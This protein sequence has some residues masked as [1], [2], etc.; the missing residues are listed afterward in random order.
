MCG[1][2]GFIDFNSV[3]QRVNLE[4]M[5]DALL[6]RGPDA[7]GYSFH[8]NKNYT[9][10][11]GHRRLSILDLSELGK[12]P[13][14][15]EN[16]EIIYNGEVYNFREV[17]DELEDFGYQFKS[18]SDT[19]VILKSFHK[20]GVNSVNKFNGMFV[21]VIYDKERDQ[22]TIIRDRGGV[23]PCYYYY[24]DGLFLFS[25]ELKSFHQH[26]NFEKEIDIQVL[27]KY[28]QH[29]YIPE[30]YSI[31]KN[32]QKLKSGCYLE[33]NL[34]NKEFI[35]REYW[36]V[37][38]FYNKPKLAIGREEAVYQTEELMKLSFKYRMVSDVPVGI[39]LSGG[40]DSSVVTGLLQKDSTDKLKTFTI[41]FEEKGFDEAPY[42][43]QVANHLGT[44]HVEYYYTQ[45]DA[46]DIFPKLSE[47]FD[48]PFGDSSVIPTVLVSQLA[49]KDV[50]V[51]LSAD[52]GDELF[53]GYSKY[54]LNLKYWNKLKKSPSTLRKVMTIG[55]GW[56]DPNNIPLFNKKYNFETKYLKLQSLLSSKSITE[57]LNKRSQHFTDNQIS[58]L[59]NIKYSGIKT[60]FDFDVTNFDDPLNEMLALDYKTYMVDDVLV[61][62][63]RATMCVSLEGREP[64][65]DYRL[66]EFLAQLPSDYKCYKGEKK[67]ILKEITHKFLPKEI[68]D[69]PK[70]GFGV[71]VMFWIKDQLREY[72]MYYLDK[73]KLEK[74]GVF[75]TYEIIRLRDR[76]LQGNAE[77]ATRLWFVLMFQMWYEKWMS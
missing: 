32:T 12:Q 1:I 9:I 58:K 57:I 55:M 29:G 40:Y 50:T 61:K 44:D 11:L 24:K 30:P 36:N 17:R 26:S 65:L 53:A 34:K 64:L 52:G 20:W 38:D 60:N 47:I 62:V 73:D 14:E 16:L 46:L 49:R 31:F 25:S 6:H 4:N 8:K 45:K 69:R 43:K 67:S 21:I 66:I 51:S 56:I 77:N 5:T 10:G 7:Y 28:L 72:F 27:G 39:F 19:E 15:F 22:V 41:G 18:D 63:D 76:F 75:N 59:L 71:P 23:K 33:F 68:M 37:I 2:A 70:K 48:E 35:C 42:A 74:Q 13:M 3:S 54:D